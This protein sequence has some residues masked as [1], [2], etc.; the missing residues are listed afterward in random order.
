MTSEYTSLIFVLVDIHTVYSNILVILLKQII[1]SNVT[2]TLPD[3][4]WLQVMLIQLFIH[5]TAEH[6]YVAAIL[7]KTGAM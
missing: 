3:E 2:K 6:M 7:L 4:N 1:Y 5:I